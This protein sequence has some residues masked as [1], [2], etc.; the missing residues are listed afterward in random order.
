M[1]LRHS[2]SWS[3]FAL[4]AVALMSPAAADDALRINQ[5]QVIGTH[6]SYHMGFAPSATRLMQSEAPQA[7]AAID[8]SHPALTRQLDDGVRQIELD[9][10]ADTKGGKYAHPSISHMIDLAGLP[11]DPPMAAPGVFDQPGFKVMHIQDIDQRST[12]QPASRSS[13]SRSGCSS[14]GCSS[15]GC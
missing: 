12:C 14:S 3:L 1:L 15:S 5:I 2:V 9:V 11:D 13:S 6:N 7:L 10:F 8:Y 4:A